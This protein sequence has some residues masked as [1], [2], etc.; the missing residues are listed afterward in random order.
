MDKDRWAV[1]VAAIYFGTFLVLGWG[2]K[3]L[4]ARWMSRRGT[5]LAELQS[6]A[7][8]GRKDGKAFLLGFWFRR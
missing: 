1:I 7:G 2:A 8:N 5:T 6:Q 3:I 4:L